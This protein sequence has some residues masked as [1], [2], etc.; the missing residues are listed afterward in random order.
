MVQTSELDDFNR[1]ERRWTCAHC[2]V[3]CG[4]LKSREI[5][6]E[7]LNFTYV[8]ISVLSLVT[9]YLSYLPRHEINSPREPED[10]F[11][12]T[13]KHYNDGFEAS[14]PV[15]TPSSIARCLY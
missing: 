4:D 13:R 14:Y 15:D 2:T 12:F 3:H 11:L 10:L 5:V 8:P 6:V 7:H 1:L 9:T